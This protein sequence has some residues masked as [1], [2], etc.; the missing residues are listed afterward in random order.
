MSRKDS[1]ADQSDESFQVRSDLKRNHNISIHS[2]GKPDRRPKGTTE[3]SSPDKVPPGSKREFSHYR[4]SRTEPK[5][6]ISVRMINGEGNFEELFP[7]D[8][9][10][11]QSVLRE[12]EEKISWADDWDR[13]EFLAF[14][15]SQNSPT[16]AHQS[17]S[18]LFQTIPELKISPGGSMYGNSDKVSGN[19]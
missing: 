17:Q 16:T 4:I 14:V 15:S 3:Y 10:R 12:K 19:S 5:P 6:D 13:E 9:E 11:K 18:P 7:D 1:S 8:E 2:R